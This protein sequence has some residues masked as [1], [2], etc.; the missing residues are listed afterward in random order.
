[1]QVLAGV[2]WWLTTGKG[3][4]SNSGHTTQNKTVKKINGEF[5]IREENLKKY[6]EELSRLRE[7]RADPM[8]C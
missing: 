8:K 2:R 5:E 7:R 3:K 6:V 4:N 1:M